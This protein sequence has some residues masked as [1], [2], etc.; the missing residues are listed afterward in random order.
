[1]DFS[2]NGSAPGQSRG[3]NHIVSQRRSTNQSGASNT[4]PFA[5]P[6]ID[7]ARERSGWE[8]DL[9]EGRHKSQNPVTYPPRMLPL[10]LRGEQ[11]REGTRAGQTWACQSERASRCLPPPTPTHPPYPFLPQR[12]HTRPSNRCLPLPHKQQSAL[13]CLLAFLS[14]PVSTCPSNRCLSFPRRLHH[15]ANARTCSTC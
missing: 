8:D 11:V 4:R 9:S 6:N 5:A 14:T 1:M 7:K 12:P 3:A 2:P 15:L 10:F 13:S